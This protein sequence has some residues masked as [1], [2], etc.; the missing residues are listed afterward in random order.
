[1]SGKNMRDWLRE[2]E[3]DKLTKLEA[4]PGVS[5]R[6]SVGVSVWAV[7]MGKVGGKLQE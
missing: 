6:V 2:Q 3:S 5:E 1:V 4:G 7:G